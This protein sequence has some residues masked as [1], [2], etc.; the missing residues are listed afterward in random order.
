MAAAAAVLLLVT[1]RMWTPQTVFPQ[2]PLLA[3]GLSVPP[4]AEWLG[5]LLLATSLIVIL[6]APQAGPRRQIGLWALAAAI[7]WLVLLDTERLQ[8]WAYQFFWMALILAT[9]PPRRAWRVLRL[10]LVSVYFFSSISKLDAVFFTSMGP[11]LLSGLFGKAVSQWPA[12]VQAG[13]SALLPLGELAVAAGLCFHKTRSRAVA[14]A[15]A[16]HGILLV[17]LGPLGVNH[18]W[19]VLTWNVF[20]M[21]QVVLLFGMRKPSERSDSTSQPKPELLTWQR[22]WQLVFAAPLLLPLLEPVGL[23]DTWTAWAVYAPRNERTEVYLHADDYGELPA[24]LR[25]FVQRTEDPDWLRLRLDQWSLDALSAPVYPQNRV[26]L[27]VALAVA[28]RFH[29]EHSLRVVQKGTSGRFSG[30][31]DETM[32]EADALYAAA[33]RYWL[34][35]LPRDNLYGFAR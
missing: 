11:Y 14:G 1:W 29:L 4:W 23:C 20:T 17:L 21:A 28:Q 19:G 22:G 5:S 3:V 30:V 13:T 6:S 18:G 27:G 34:N 7:A 2:V 25:R 10:F 16:M 12:G 15:C 8:V 24:N 32:L 35:A 26:Q 31:R 9:L 33:A